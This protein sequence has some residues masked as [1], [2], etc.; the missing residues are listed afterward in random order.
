MLFIFFMLNVQKF[1]FN[2]LGE[3]TYVVWS[4]NK[5]C[6]IIDPGCSNS[7]ENKILSDFIEQIQ[8]RPIILLNTHCHVDHVPGNH[9]VV[10]KYNIPL[11]ISREELPLLQSAPEVAK[12]FGLK[13]PP[14]PAPSGFLSEGDIWQLGEEK[15]KVISTPGHSPG[16]LSFWAED[17]EWIIVGDVLFNG[18]VG[19]FDLPG[20]DGPTLFRSIQEKL[21]TLPDHVVVYSGHG[22]DT[23]IGTERKYNPFLQNGLQG[24]LS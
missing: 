20:S 5:E 6:A 10:E 21:M 8:L 7:Y 11:Y 13:C 9:Y 4:K 17:S 2:P 3:N 22:P 15:I 16:G 14:S 24:F 1:T 18:S 23:T 12:F 19:R